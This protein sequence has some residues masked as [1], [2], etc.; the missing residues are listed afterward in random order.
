MTKFSSVQL[1]EKPGCVPYLLYTESVSKNNPGGLKHRK[2]ESKQVTHYANRERPEH[3]FVETYRQY[4]LHRPSDVEDDSFYLA[5]IVNPK[6]T[7]WF[8]K[9]PI[10]AHTLV[11]TVRCLCTKASVGGYKTN[12]SL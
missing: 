2:V 1:V 12:H 11:G 10:G 5:P 6:G 7:V 9:Q 4:C 8:K 3:C